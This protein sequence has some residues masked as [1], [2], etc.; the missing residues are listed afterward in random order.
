MLSKDANIIDAIT[1][2]EYLIFSYL[3]AGFLKE[4]CTESG[5]KLNLGLVQTAYANGSSTKYINEKLV[6]QIHS[7]NFVTEYFIL[8]LLTSYQKRWNSIKLTRNFVIEH[9]SCLHTY[10]RKT[11][12]SQG[13]RF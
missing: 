4:L 5:V 12:T 3:V 7:D 9:S 2:F 1:F 10:W 13:I 11:F 8:I 6:M